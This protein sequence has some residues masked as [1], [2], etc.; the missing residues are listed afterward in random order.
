MFRIPPLLIALL[1]LPS[2]S[3][4]AAAPPPLLA[5]PA[6][7]AVDTAA[8]LLAGLPPRGYADAVPLAADARWQR[9]AR[10]LD[11]SWEQLEKRQLSK[12]RRW[13]AT[14]LPET[15]L[16]RGTVF[17]MFSG[18]DF[19]YAD[20]FYPHAET[21]IL[22]GMEAVGPVPDPA[23]LPPHLINGELRGLRD[24]INSILS[25][26]FFLTKEMK[27]D[28]YNRRL[29]GTLPVLCLFLARTGKTITAIEPLELDAEGRAHP[30]K[31]GTRLARH[32]AP[33]VRITFHTDPPGRPRTLYYFCTDISDSGLKNSGFLSFCRSFGQ[34]VSCVKSASYLMH[35]SYF[36]GVRS[37]LLEQSGMLVQDDSGVPCSFF[38]D[39]AWQVAYFGRYPGPIPLFKEYRQPQLAR[40]YRSGNPTPLDFGI[41]Y[42]HRIGESMLMVA[43]KRPPAT[44][45]T[46]EHS[47]PIP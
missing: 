17:Y 7:A 46:A 8:R 29:S 44:P 5:A 45:E 3:C 21:Y 35:K 27:G 1:L 11:A 26:S 43:S 37:F 16:S 15:A 2:A 20:A 36:S 33:G 38:G 9:H 13:S 42:R 19:L 10:L 25:F 24:S 47:N 31:E 12:V 32:S 6:P 14:N 4:P 34:G 22:C 18:P 39:D 28:L 40:N 41:G 23:A 30:R